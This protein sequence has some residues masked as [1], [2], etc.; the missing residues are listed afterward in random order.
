[1]KNFNIEESE[2]SRILS[3][4]KSLLKEQNSTTKTK[5]IDQ[6]LQ[7]FITNGCFPN[8]NPKVVPMNS[9]NPQKTYAI[10]IEST[11]TPG[12]FRYFF[13]DKTVGEMEGGTFK[14]LKDPWSC[15]KIPQVNQ[16]QLTPQQQ[17][18]IDDLIN[19]YN[20]G[21]E[22]RFKKEEPTADQMAKKEWTKVNLKDIQEFKDIGI[23]FDYYVWEKTG[24]RQTQSPQQKAAI[25]TYTDA[26]WQDIGGKVNPA[27]ASKYDTVDLKDI[28]PKD[29]LDSY[30]LVKTI[31]SV[32]TNEVIKEL[33]TLVGT[34]NFGDRKTCRDIISK[35]NVAK[36]KNAPVNDALL[37]NWK[38]AVNACKTKVSN[39][40]DLNIT[41][42]IY[43]TLTVPPTDSKG[44]PIKAK[45][46]KEGKDIPPT[47]ATEIDNRWGVNI[48][49]TPKK[50]TQSSSGTPTAGAPTN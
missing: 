13:V 46:D 35:Y 32:D 43:G 8:G 26:G 6:Q 5:T 15:N 44:N 29:F 16:Q 34:K 10:K 49:V 3:M 2:K 25:K 41:N 37:R 50:P 19:T 11:K 45:Q 1:M 36:K 23:T 20:Q 33:N 30:K 14:F 18:S 42:T 47:P 40:N 21:P 9:T 48:L 22:P 27:E 24:L 38:I 12:K 4:H 31:E 28:Y 39:F 17:K 7:E